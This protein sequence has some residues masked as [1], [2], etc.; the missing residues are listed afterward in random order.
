[1][2]ESDK[3]IL[4]EIRLCVNIYDL[5]SLRSIHRTSIDQSSALLEA[6]D[7]MEDVLSRTSIVRIGI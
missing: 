2:R 3:Q 4:R 7:D 5:E 6:Y 1:M